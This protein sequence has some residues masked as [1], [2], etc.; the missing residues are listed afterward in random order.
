MSAR[1]DAIILAIRAQVAD[2]KAVKILLDAEIAHGTAMS[3]EHWRN[4]QLEIRSSLG[5]LLTAALINGMVEIS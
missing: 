5:D 2:Y 3:S 1:N 4:R